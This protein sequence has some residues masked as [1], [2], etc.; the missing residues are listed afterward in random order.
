M[1]CQ[2]FRQ[3]YIYL[4]HTDLPKS[5]TYTCNVKE[6][7]SLP[8][9]SSISKLTNYDNTMHLATGICLFLKPVRSPQVFRCPF[10]ATGWLAQVDTLLES[11]TSLLANSY[12]SFVPYM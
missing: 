3:R 12:I 10:N 7:F 8:I 1:D 5:A 9:N 11:P 4:D 6:W 2:T